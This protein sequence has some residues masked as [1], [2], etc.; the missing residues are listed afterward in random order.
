MDKLLKVLD[1][2]M[3]FVYQ[4]SLSL[5]DVCVIVII[6]ELSSNFHWAFWGL[7]IPWVFYS[8]HQKVKYDK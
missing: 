6:S 7:M 4:S 3:K 8:A 5:M 2:F 1:S